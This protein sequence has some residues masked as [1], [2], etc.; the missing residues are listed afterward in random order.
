MSRLDDL[1]SVHEKRVEIAR[2]I[3]RARMW[4]EVLQRDLSQIGFTPAEAQTFIDGMTPREMTLD[5]YRYA[6]HILDVRKD[7]RSALSWYD[8]DID[9]NQ[10]E[11][12]LF[13]WAAREVADGMDPFTAKGHLTVELALRGLPEVLLP[14]YSDPE[15]WDSLHNERAHYEYLRSLPRADLPTI[16]G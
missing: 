2:R 16:D 14:F 7:V 11:D 15:F 5:E 12:D 9:P 4:E 6:M 13:H 8:I 10:S 1:A 3:A